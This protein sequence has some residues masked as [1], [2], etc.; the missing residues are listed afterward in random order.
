MSELLTL[1][2]G[3]ALPGDRPHEA[4]EDGLVETFVQLWLHRPDGG[5]QSEGPV[6]VDVV[7]GP[8]QP[9]Q[10]QRPEERPVPHDEELFSRP[11][12]S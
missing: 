8:P 7:A 11:Q 1:E 2:D 12:P 4:V 10:D 5:S 3:S 6:H 9:R